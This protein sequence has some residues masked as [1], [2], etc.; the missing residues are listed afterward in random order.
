MS[1]KSTLSSTC[2]PNFALSN[3]AHFSGLAVHSHMPIYRTFDRCQR[4]QIL[5]TVNNFESSVSK[6][7]SRYEWNKL[8]GHFY[9]YYFDSST[10][11][12]KRRNRRVG[13]LS[14]SPNASTV[15]LASKLVR[16]HIHIHM[17][18]IYYVE[19]L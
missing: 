11:L 10:V 4:D 3:N 16:I 19:M 2:H 18:Y 13:Y 12:N 6:L 15:T 17:L 7:K 1:L 8:N 5:G 9:D 14:V